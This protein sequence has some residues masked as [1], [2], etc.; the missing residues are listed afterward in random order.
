M[1]LWA[2]PTRL[3]H[4]GPHKEYF[5]DPSRS[6]LPDPAAI[7][8][9]QGPTVP[10][11]SFGRPRI[12]QALFVTNIILSGVM[13]G[14]LAGIGLLTWAY[15]QGPYE[16][17]SLEEEGMMEEISEM[18]NEHPDLER[19]IAN[20]EWEEWGVTSMPLSMNV[21]GR[22]SHLVNGTLNRSKG[23]VLVS[24]ADDLKAQFSFVLF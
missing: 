20:P 8:P 9:E 22:R 11:T 18:L 19:L 21:V 2:Q 1:P 10:P 5:Q 15:V 6:P 23:I 12:R 14:T 16:E 3:Q 4:D 17:G 7:I 13:G 24:V